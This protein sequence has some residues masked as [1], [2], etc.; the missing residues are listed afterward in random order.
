MAAVDSPPHSI[1]PILPPPV[2]VVMSCFY[3]RYRIVS[4]LAR[5]AHHR[6]TLPVL[7]EIAR[8]RG[9]R[10]AALTG[11]LGVSRESLRRTL[12]ALQTEELVVRNPGYGHPLR[13]EYLLTARGEAVAP[14]ARAALAAA[15]GH[16]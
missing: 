16:E 8:S 10:V 5:L 4:T 9:S 7:A 2:D 14:A 1:L 12:A 6:W 3:T 11:T 15:H 13:P